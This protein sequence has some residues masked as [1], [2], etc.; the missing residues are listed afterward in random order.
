MPSTQRFLALS[1]LV[2]TPY[3]LASCSEEAADDDGGSGTGTTAG[4]G[5]PAGGTGGSSGSGPGGTGGTPAAGTGTGGGGTGP[6]GG[7]GSS[8]GKGGSGAGTGGAGTGGAVGGAGGATAGGAGSGSSGGGAG[9]A[10]GGAGAGGAGGAGGA[11]GGA[12]SGGASGG[13]GKSGGGEFTLTSAKLTPGEE[14]S[15]DFTCEGDAH[16]PP[17]EWTGVPEGTMSFAMLFVDM[18]IAATN[19]DS[20]MAWHHAIWDIPA[21]ATGLPEDMPT[22][23]TVT[24]PVACKQFNPL[25]CDGYLGPCAQKEDEYEFRLYALPVATLTGTLTSVVSIRNAVMAANPLGEAVLPVKANA[26]GS[27]SC[28]K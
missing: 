3:I 21:S 10:T 9:G 20:S 22:T 6:A 24:T 18:T 2:T 27:L 14:M 4:T 16:S 19:M 11:L 15:A 28:P 7:G 23:A 17:F 26:S 13:G 1:L 12:G 8:A 5:N 25:Q